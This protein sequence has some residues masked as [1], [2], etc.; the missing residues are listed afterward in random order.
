MGV[1]VAVVAYLS[2][3][4]PAVLVEKHR[5][6][7]P[8]AGV[9]SEDQ[10]SASDDVLEIIGL[11]LAGGQLQALDQA[12]DLGVGE[13]DLHDEEL[14]LEPLNAVLNTIHHKR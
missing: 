13:M 8:A 2:A 3:L 5:P 14:L 6:G 9:E 4:R 1:A 11:G 12:L 10:G 7:V